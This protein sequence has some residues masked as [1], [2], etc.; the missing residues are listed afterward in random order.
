MRLNVYASLYMVALLV[1]GCAGV[2]PVPGG[3]ETI[4]A[5]YYQSS[6]DFR[7]RVGLLNP[8]MG[9]SQVMSILGRTRDDM[10][11]LSRDEVVKALYGGATVQMLD[12]AHEREETRQFLESLYGYQLQYKD[13]TKHHGFVSPIRI[14][15]REEGFAYTLNLVFQNGILMERPVLA[16]GAVNDTSSRTVFDY[17][18]PGTVLAQAK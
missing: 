7:T 14:S 10:T 8:G 13:V 5:A 4:N 3:G 16:G 12:T 9:E 17:I 6:D 18:N 2:A 1:A 11:Q 15:T